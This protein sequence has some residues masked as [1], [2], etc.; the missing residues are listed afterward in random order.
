[1]NATCQLNVLR[2]DGNPPSLNCYQITVFEKPNQ[3][4]FTG[5]LESFKSVLG[6]PQIS[7]EVLSNL[8]NKPTKY[9]VRYSRITND[10]Q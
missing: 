9:D 5:F 3:V 10:K 2:H 4:E 8:P 6:E 7:L 1:M